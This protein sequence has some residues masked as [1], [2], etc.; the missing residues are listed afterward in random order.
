MQS[1]RTSASRFRSS[2]S[3]VLASL[4]ALA[5]CNGDPECGAGDAAA[6]GIVAGGESVTLTFGSFE[7]GL[8]NDCPAADQPDDVISLTI[9]ATQTD[10]TGF[11]TLCV[12]RP[13]RLNGTLA[14]GVHER[15]SDV[16]IVDLIGE[17]NGCSFR[18]LQANP[19][20]GTARGSGACALG[21]DPAG[22]ALEIDGEL[23]LQRTCD[24]TV[25]TVTV[26]LAG[27]VAV[28]PQ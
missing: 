5:G 16:H 6:A 3:G 17:A 21:V 28:Q 23:V 2:T 24:A 12:E 27:K 7:A 4:V 18:Y 22:F 20:S 8:N 10:G 1:S 13:D 25:D 15:G 14:L 26:T 9:A 11:L 19:P